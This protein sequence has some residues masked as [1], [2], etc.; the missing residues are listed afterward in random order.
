M[1]AD[2]ETCM[3]RAAALLPDFY[4]AWYAAME[5]YLKLPCGKQSR[6]QR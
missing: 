4:D 5:A 2:L 3:A 1:A 6:I